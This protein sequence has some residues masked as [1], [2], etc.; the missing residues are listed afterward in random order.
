MQN[1]KQQFSN[2][3]N[4]QENSENLISLLD[5]IDKTSDEE[6]FTPIGNFTTKRK[7]KEK[8]NKPQNQ[9]YHDDIVHILKYA[10]ENNPHSLLIELCQ[11]LKWTFPNINSYEISEN[12]IN[13][14]KTQIGLK[15]F[16]G[17]AIGITKKISKSKPNNIY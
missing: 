1:E 8:S 15:S 4:N 2:F 10:E 6:N 7:T 16:K 12:N 13:V 17:D 3:I 11:S 14:Y 5:N 9:K